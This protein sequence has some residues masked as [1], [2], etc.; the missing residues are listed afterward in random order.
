MNTEILAA[1]PK[2]VEAFGA[3]RATDFEFNALGKLSISDVALSAALSRNRRR[4]W[5][6]SCDIIIPTPPPHRE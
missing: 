5:Q 2:I 4:L 1:T 3:L 6:S